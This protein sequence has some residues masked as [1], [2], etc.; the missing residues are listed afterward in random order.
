MLGAKR[1]VSWLEVPRTVVYAWIGQE[2]LPAWPSRTHGLTIPAMHI[3]GPRWGVPRLKNVIDI[4][5]NAELASGFF[6][7]ERQFEDGATLHL[8][9]LTTGCT[10]DVIDAAGRCRAGLS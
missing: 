2:R 9:V 7:R 10:G 1:A 5:G 3:L 6:T 4:M 8:D